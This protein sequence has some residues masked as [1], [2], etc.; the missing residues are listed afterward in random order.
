M[1]SVFE[2][3]AA[4]LGVPEEAFDGPSF[5]IVIECL[6]DI[7]LVTTI[8]HSSLLSRFAAKCTACFAGP[9]CR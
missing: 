7:R 2:I 4:C 9:A 1:R 8:S 6:P 5:A 3:E